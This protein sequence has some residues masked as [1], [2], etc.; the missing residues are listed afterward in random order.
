MIFTKSEIENIIEEEAKKYLVELFLV[1]YTVKKGDTLSAI[2]RAHGVDTQSLLGANPHIKDKNVIRIGDQIKIPGQ[3]KPPEDKVKTTNLEKSLDEPRENKYWGPDW[4]WKQSDDEDGVKY[5]ST[6]PENLKANSEAIKE[7]KATEVMKCTDSGCARWV[8]DILKI[9]SDFRGHAWH[10]HGMDPYPSY[11]SFKFDMTTASEAAKIFAKINKNPS[12]NLNSTIKGFVQNF[13]PNQASLKS[14]LNLGDI[15]GLYWAN[16]QF[17]HYCFFEGATGYIS[18]GESKGV[19]PAR[20]PYF[21]NSNAGR[22]WTWDDVGK[23]VTFTPRRRLLDGGGFGMNTHLGFVGATYKGEPVIFHQVY[24]HVW[25]EPLSSID[26]NRMAVLWSKPAEAKSSWM[27]EGGNQRRPVKIRVI[28]EGPPQS[29]L[30]SAMRQHPILSSSAPRN[31][32]VAIFVV[33]LAKKKIMSSLDISDAALKL[34]TSAAIGISGR[35]SS[36]E[37]G[38]IYRYTDWAETLVSQIGDLVGSTGD[39]LNPSIGATQLKYH[40]HFKDSAPLAAYADA[41]GIKGPGDLG[42]Y[43]KAIIATIGVLSLLYKKAVSAGYSTGNPGVSRK[44]FTSTGNAALDL[45]LVGYSAAPSWITS[46]C[47]TDEIKKKC[48]SAPGEPV[49]KNYIPALET[50][51]TKRPGLV[52][53]TLSY[54]SEVAGTMKKYGPIAGLI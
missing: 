38:T 21:V 44:Q 4:I 16:S 5:L 18:R 23:D 17:F 51:S 36:F 29:K 8:S 52:L 45:A 47:G 15:V 6:L 53:S 54:V 27:F 42:D 50:P 13:I 43:P 35:E 39:V 32:K 41:L 30:R 33:S 11:S 25:A 14:Q 7:G 1:E 34:L 28:R 20:G 48:S 9:G 37:K 2:A 46:Y 3:E 10:M 12:I 24:G 26:T 31:I 19:K 22:K 40:W 49:V